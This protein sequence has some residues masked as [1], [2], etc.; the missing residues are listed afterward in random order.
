MRGETIVYLSPCM[1]NSMWRHSQQIMSRLAQD[2]KVLFMEPGRN[3]DRPAGSEFRRNLHNLWSLRVQ[4]V[5]DNLL[6]IPTPSSLPL[7]REVLPAWLLKI[8][9]PVV[10]R[11]NAQVL[12]WYLRR[13]LR[14]LGVRNP[15]LWLSSPD[16]Y[17]MI[18][19]LGEK[20]SVYFV[21]DEFAEFV[22]NRRIKGLLQ[23]LD[24]RLCSRV[25][26]VLG[27]STAICEQ[28]R[29]INPHCYFVPNGVDFDLYNQALQPDTP[30]PS[31][32]ASIPRPII[33]FAGWIGYHID[34]QLLTRVAEAYPQCSLVLVGPDELGDAEGRKRLQALPNV[35]FLGK[36]ARELLP[37][38]LRV[39]DV[40]LMPY[41][42]EGHVRWAY[43][44]KLHEYLAAGLPIVA[45]ALPALEP[46]ARFVR[47]AATYDQFVALI[48]EAFQ[49]HSP[50]T[51]AARVAV[52]RENTWDER[53]A[54][55]SRL[56]EPWLGAES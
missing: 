9:G 25:D 11:I 48:G 28:R 45:T 20:V 49:D 17:P 10:M 27:T 4:S 12:L 5:H 35:F 56:L 38:Y 36:K 40:G 46:Y 34:A 15:I 23:E 47:I 37:Q 13:A 6:V 44:L 29:V 42:L 22:H 19:K 26:V 7:A 30:I 24:D 8:L 16:Y 1:W 32:I 52:A 31:D 51:I 50:E 3:P 55:M 2:N 33:G 41:L 14:S 18:G 53:V 43:P 54:Q 39:F 21:Y